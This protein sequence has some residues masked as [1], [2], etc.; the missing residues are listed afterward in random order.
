MSRAVTPRW[1]GS[2]ALL[3]TLAT[4]LFSVHG[5]AMIEVS[6]GLTDALFL[7]DSAWRRDWAWLRS[8]LSLM[9]LFW[10]G[11]LVICSLPALSRVSFMNLIRSMRCA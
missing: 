10:W 11:W 6:I 2:V 7:L 4:P 8:G 5:R 9:G 1:I 3:A